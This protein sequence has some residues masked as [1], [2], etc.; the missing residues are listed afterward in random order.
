Q[1]GDPSR[2]RV[3]SIRHRSTVSDLASSQ[4]QDDRP[5][6]HQNVADPPSFRT[7]RVEGE[8]RHCPLL[9]RFHPL[10]PPRAGNLEATM[11]YSGKN[12]VVL[13]LGHSGEAAAILLREEGAEVTICES[14][15]NSA[16]REK[17]A[18]LK[19]QDI[20]RL[21]P[22]PR[23]RPAGSARA[24]RSP[25]KDSHHRRTRAGLRRMHLPGSRHYRHQW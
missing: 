5:A 15:D 6:D 18:K 25:E 10:R 16:L 23:Q 17:A 11:I 3:R 19:E 12:A 1:A 9:D 2:Y 21:H 4:L 22:E 8:Y 24:E 20:R 13:G 7:K 14:S